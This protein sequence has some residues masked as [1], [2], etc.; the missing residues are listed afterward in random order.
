MSIGKKEPTQVKSTA[1]DH[2]DSRRERRFLGAKLVFNNDQSVIDCVLRDISA[3]GA[4]VRDNR[5]PETKTLA[6]PELD[7]AGVINCHQNDRPR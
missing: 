4:R 6:V 1:D 5:K 7:V 3:T 2:R